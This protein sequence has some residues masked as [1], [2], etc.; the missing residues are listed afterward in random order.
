MVRT[1][2]HYRVDVVMPSATIVVQAIDL[3]GSALYRGKHRE[4]VTFFTS[5]RLLWPSWLVYSGS[6]GGF[7]NLAKVDGKQAGDKS[8]TFVRTTVLLRGQCRRVERG[9]EKE[10]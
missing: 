6:R 9:A 5:P 2:H 3:P 1:S 7:C 10:K 8:L 4:S